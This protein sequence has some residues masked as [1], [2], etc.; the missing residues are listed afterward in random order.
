VIRGKDTTRVLTVWGLVP[1]A[2]G[3]ACTGGN[4]LYVTSTSMRDARGA[5]LTGMGPLASLPPGTDGETDSAPPPDGGPSVDPEPGPTPGPDATGSLVDAGATTEAGATA[6][7]LGS[8]PPP[9]APVDAGPPPVETA[10]DLAPVDTTPPPPPPP[11]P[12]DAAPDTTPSTTHGL[13]GVYYKGRNFE[14]K[15][16]ERVDQLIN[17]GWANGSPAASLP[18]DNFSVRWSG[19]IQV[20]LTGTYQFHT[21]SD[22]GV[23]VSI[24][25]LPVISAWMDQTS[26]EHEGQLNLTAGVRTPIEIE[27]YERAY[28]ATMRL[29]WQIPGYAREP[30]PASAFWVP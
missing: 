11:P 8:P 3:L 10:P 7:D 9:P 28:T 4:P 29:S 19:Y 6:D 25:G 13:L 15:V 16:L 14:E 22:D 17:F 27:Y 21:E 20:P 2:L 1:L 24:G 5:D 18:V 12:V 26:G 30:I 23:R